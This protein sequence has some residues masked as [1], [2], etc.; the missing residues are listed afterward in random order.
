V[1]VV[2]AVAVVTAWWVVPLLLLDRYSVDFLDHI[3]SAVTTTSVTS[4]VETLRGT[5]DWVAYVPAAGW[6]AGQ[7]YLTQSA[8]LLNSVLIVALGLAGL[9]LSG[10]RQRRWG[11]LCLVA[12]VCMVGFGFHADAG[13]A[14]GLGADQFG[15]RWTVR[16]PPRSTHKFDVVCLPLV[17]GVVH[18]LQSGRMGRSTASAPPREHRGGAR[19]GDRRRHGRPAHLAEAGAVTDFRRPARLLARGGRLAGRPRPGRPGPNRPGSAHRTV[20]VGTDR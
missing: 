10:M 6:R 8:I 13:W 11:V 19:R 14:H 3:E 4:A 9:A 12:G 1:L 15:A 2:A 20:R 17:L 16:W 18:L 5:A 7:L